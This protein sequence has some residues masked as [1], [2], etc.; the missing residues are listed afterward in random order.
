MS[1]QNQIEAN[2]PRMSE[3]DY[4]LLAVEKKKRGA[5][6]AEAE[7]IA[8]NSVSQQEIDRLVSWVNI[9]LKNNT[10]YRDTVRWYAN[11]GVDAG[12]RARQTLEQVRK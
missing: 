5:R 3:E 11:G 1:G 8:A 10:L 4:R 2:E 6:K 9:L 12:E 7:E